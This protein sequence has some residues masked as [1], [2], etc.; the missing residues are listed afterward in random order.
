MALSSFVDLVRD[1]LQ[2]SLEPAP[3]LVGD[4]YPADAAD[5]PAVTI[6]ISGASEPLRGV[7]RLPAPTL[8]GALRVE[9]SLDLENPVV[10]FPDED[11]RLLSDDRRVVLL[12]HGP[13]VRADASTTPPWR[14]ADLAVALGAT[15]FAPV[16]GNPAAGQVQVLVDTGEL[17]FASPLPD[18]GTLDLGYF[19]GEWEVRTARYRGDLNLEAFAEDRAGV[20]TLSRQIGDALDSPS[21]PGLQQLS[22]TAWGP[23]G[24]V[25]A[26]RGNARSLAL[27]YRFDYE[28]IEPKLATGGG[29]IASVAVDS[30]PGPEHFDVTREGS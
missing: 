1:F 20:D 24:A 21:I 19:V 2:T 27:T 10:A 7:G 11:V 6:S 25:D 23:V 28:L 16:A 26:T 15:T 12:A 14:Q 9:T 4:G 8:T 22:P 5:L 29:L 13:L 3:A 17:R 18:T 30:A